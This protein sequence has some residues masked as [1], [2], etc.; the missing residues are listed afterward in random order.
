MAFKMH[1][2]KGPLGLP[3]LEVPDG[4]FFF[5]RLSPGEIREADYYDTFRWGRGGTKLFAC[6]RGKSVKGRCKEPLRLL[7]IRHRKAGLSKLVKDCESGE[8][9]KR[10]E[11][12]IRQ[13]LKDTGRDANLEGLD[14][15]RFLPIAAIGLFVLFSLVFVR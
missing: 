3:L 9:F 6:L 15:G 5:E 14:V 4:P 12:T 11:K 2:C 13:I 7:R 8:L 1:K 10:R